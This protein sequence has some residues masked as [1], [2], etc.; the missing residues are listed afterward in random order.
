MCPI[1][2]ILLC[3]CFCFRGF[4]TE[5]WPLLL[6]RER[7]L[8]WH[9]ESAGQDNSC[10]HFLCGPEQP[11]GSEWHLNCSFAVLSRLHYT[12]VCR[13]DPVNGSFLDD[14]HWTALVCT[15]KRI[16]SPIFHPESL[17][18]TFSIQGNLWH[19]DWKQCSIWC[20]SIS[21]VKTLDGVFFKIFPVW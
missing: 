9:L 18:Q 1:E 19:A 14:I 8:C 20:W 15:C 21:S 5:I 10:F 11:S 7:S 13:H 6:E 16:L 4:I 2:T 17:L 3:D 12:S